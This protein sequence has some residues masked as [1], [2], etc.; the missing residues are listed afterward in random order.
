MLIEIT[1]MSTPPS[2]GYTSPVSDSVGSSPAT[3]PRDVLVLAAAKV[4]SIDARDCVD[5]LKDTLIDVSAALK[6]SREITRTLP[7]PKGK[8]RKPWGKRV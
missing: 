6:A 1:S 7:P 4:A 5:S 3:S 8:T 2:T